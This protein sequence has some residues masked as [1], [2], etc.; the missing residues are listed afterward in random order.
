MKANLMSCMKTVL[1][2]LATAV[3]GLLPAQA[4]NYHLSESASGVAAD[5]GDPAT[6]GRESGLPGSGDQIYVDDNLVLKVTDDNVASLSARGTTVYCTT[7]AKV[8]IDLA[9]NAELKAQFTY[10]GSSECAGVTKTGAGTLTLTLIDNPT[11]QPSSSRFVGLKQRWHVL[12]G[13]LVF[14]QPQTKISATSTIDLLDIGA[15]CTVVSINGYVVYAQ[16][17]GQGNLEYRAADPTRITIESA[18]AGYHG[19]ILQA[20]NAGT[21]QIYVNGGAMLYGAEGTAYTTPYITGGPVGLGRFG[22]SGSPATLGT[23]GKFNLS[24]DAHF[25]ALGTTEETSDKQFVLG[26][27]VSTV[28]VDGGTFGGV[29]FTG[30]WNPTGEI[31]RSLILSGSNTEHACVLR[32]TIADVGTGADTC[33]YHLVKKGTGAWRMASANPK[34]SG[35]MT[36]EEGTLKF[37]TIAPAGTACSLGFA[38]NLYAN[39]PGTKDEANRVDW[40]VKLGNPGVG[41]VAT[42]EYAGTAA[43]EW[44]TSRPIVVDGRGRFRNATGVPFTLAG[45]KAVVPDSVLV[46]DGDAASAN[47]LSGASENGNASLAIEKEGPGTWMLAGDVAV[48]GGLNVRAGEVKIS[49][50]SKFDWFKV[51]VKQTFDGAKGITS[52]GT[53]T[54]QEFALYDVNGVRQN[55]N[56]TIGEPQVGAAA[57]TLEPGGLAYGPCCAGTETGKLVNMT[58]ANTTDNWAYRA[59]VMPD[60]GVKSTWVSFVIRVPEGTPEIEKF[61]LRYW[62]TTTNSGNSPRILTIEG[63]VDGLEWASLATVTNP[64]VAAGEERTSYQY[65]LYGDRMKYDAVRDPANSGLAFD[66]PAIAPAEMRSSVEIGGAWSVAS[67]ASLSVD[68]EPLTLSRLELDFAVGIGSFDNVRLSDETG[69]VVV[70]NVPK[71]AVTIPADFTGVGNLEAVGGWTVI[72]EFGRPFKRKVVIAPTSV[73]VLANGLMLILR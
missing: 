15:G 21:V 9:G 39:V 54:I 38:T 16:L 35:A 55:L 56:P 24:S 23:S 12:G 68:G 10:S 42:L 45:V 18:R 73:S 50:K 60:P 70:K 48:S 49:N 19:N 33:S 64:P 37:D 57:G 53:V 65:W 61:D 13:T 36:I 17:A 1:C 31:M 63:S 72:D 5:F 52:A 28:E 20:A 41:E 59:N 7:K 40:A 62:K 71:G 67:A 66:V 11:I 34:W 4:E 44:P 69:V 8:E 3:F 47:T 25:L 30:A 43:A 6:Y 26:S 46:L 51:T 27:A 2:G 29:T 22:M 32:N 14:P 58:Y